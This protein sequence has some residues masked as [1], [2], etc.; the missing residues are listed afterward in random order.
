VVCLR[1]GEPTVRQWPLAIGKAPLGMAVDGRLGR[2]LLT[3]EA[4]A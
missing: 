3:R 4:V 1:L 2:L